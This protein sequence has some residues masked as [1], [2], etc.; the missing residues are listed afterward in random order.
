MNSQNTSNNILSKIDDLNLKNLLQIQNIYED[1]GFKIFLV[2]GAVRDALLGKKIKDFDLATDAPLD[3]TKDAFRQ[4]IPTGEDFGTLTLLL[5][6]CEYEITRFRKDLDTDGR[7]ATIIEFADTLEEDVTRRDLTIN[8]LAFDIKNNELIDYV[9]GLKD[10]KNKKINFIGNTA[11]RIKEDQLRSLRFYRFLHRYPTFTSSKDT[12]SILTSITNLEI[13]SIER[14]FQELEKM[15]SYNIPVK[16]SVINGLVNIGVL[17]RLGIDKKFSESFII[18]KKMFEYNSILPIIVTYYINHG[19]DTKKTIQTL[20]ISKN[21]KYIFKVIDLIRENK[22]INPDILLKSSM[23]YI[24]DKNELSV[25][26][27]IFNISFNS[28]LFD[29]ILENNIPINIS[30]LEINGNDLIKLGFSG[31]EIKKQ[32]NFLLSKVWIDDSL[33]QKNI[34]LELISKNNNKIIKNNKKMLK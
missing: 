17:N 29:K 1:N 15:L 14:I 32:L 30:D 21:Y 33:N 4:V 5:N 25:L 31:S 22:K 34:L 11:D 16:D 8:G 28:K 23:R 2:G 26:F 3:F 19:F 20:K 13:V 12:D 9:N 6:D 10:I 7:R 18:L 27:S 24:S